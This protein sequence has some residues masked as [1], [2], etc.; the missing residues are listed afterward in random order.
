[1]MLKVSLA[2][3]VPTQAK[4]QLKRVDMGFTR[5]HI[6][7]SSPFLW[8]VGGFIPSE[9]HMSSSV[10]MMKFPMMMEKTSHG[11]NHQAG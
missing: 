7:K 3:Q 10:G 5:C 6:S 4:E 9:K 11:P 2:Y 1:M 8:L